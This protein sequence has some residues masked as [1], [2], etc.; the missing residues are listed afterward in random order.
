MY[1]PVMP[2]LAEEVFASYS[3]HSQ[4]SVFEE[5]YVEVPAEWRDAGVTQQWRGWR[6][7]PSAVECVEAVRS[8]INR[9]LERL[10]KGGVIRSGLEVDVG[11]MPGA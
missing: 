8:E 5:G 7:R 6:T 4:H 9:E 11:L 2:F 3:Q 1:A 10:K